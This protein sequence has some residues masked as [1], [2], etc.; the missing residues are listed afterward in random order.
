MKKK[1][2]GLLS[3]FYQAFMFVFGIYIAALTYNT[4]LQPNSIVI[5]GTTGLSVIFEHLL[6]WN[7]SI[8]ILV[9]GA[10]LLGISFK[11]LGY[12]KTRKN[13]IGTFLYPIMIAFSE[14]VA[15][16]ILPYITIDDFVVTII[17]AGLLYG[18][19]CGLVYKAGYS[20]G[21][22]DVIMQLL[23]K[24]LK[25][26]EGKASLVANIIVILSGLPIIGFRLTLYSV[27]AL[28]VASYVMSKITVG[29]SDSK[30]FFVYTKKLDRVRDALVKDGTTGFTIIPTLGGYSHYKGELLMCVVNTK[31][32]YE[33]RQIVL[34]IDENAFFVINDCYE[35]N[36]GVKRQHL[37]FL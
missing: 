5:G 27:I 17:L 13:I 7:A 15:K 9:V 37:P 14:P 3:D 2:K 28:Y 25:M 26:P 8:F 10:L 19:G 23:N 30:L 31:D 4:F 11:F 21:G 36:G 18:F 6:G 29:I 34:N 22:F 20:T 32:Y 16:L 24:Y 35:V 1:K 33:F 12:E